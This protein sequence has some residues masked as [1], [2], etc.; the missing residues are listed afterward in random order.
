M[1]KVRLRQHLASTPEEPEADW[2]LLFLAMKLISGFEPGESPSDRDL[3]K[4]TKSFF[5][6][7][8][9]RNALSLRL[10]QSAILIAT[11]EVGHAIYPAAYL[12]AGHC[13]RLCHAVGLHDPA[14]AVS[15]LPQYFTW[16]EGVCWRPLPLRF[17]LSEC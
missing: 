5:I 17:E 10:I 13:A 11:Y 4:I 16:T 3:Y 6:F 14:R 1:S 2:S 9:S 15:M 8:E 12:S 7:L